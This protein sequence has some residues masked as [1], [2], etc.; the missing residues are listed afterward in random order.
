MYLLQNSLI[1]DLMTINP[2]NRPSATQAMTRLKDIAEEAAEKEF[3]QDF[4]G[5]FE[6]LFSQL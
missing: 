1:V 4:A 2:A 3:V 6:R 5:S